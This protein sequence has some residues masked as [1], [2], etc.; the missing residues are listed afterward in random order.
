[1]NTSLQTVCDLRSM[2]KSMRYVPPP[3][4][5]LLQQGIA[6][7]CRRLIRRGQFMTQTSRPFPPIE[8]WQDMSETEQDALLDKIETHRRRTYLKA[9]TI[10]LAICALA[11]IG[12]T[13]VLSL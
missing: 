3:R 7:C 11:L 2:R 10:S 12:V 1:M 5:T 4:L 8:H 13:L 6:A 9:R